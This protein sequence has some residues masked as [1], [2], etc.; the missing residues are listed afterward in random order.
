MAACYIQHFTVSGAGTFP[1]DMLRYDGCHPYSGDDVAALGSREI[2]SIRLSRHVE[3][4][5]VAPTHE[6]WRLFGWTVQPGSVNTF[7]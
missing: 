3:H 5:A 1:F 4:K 7:R 6:R 2:R